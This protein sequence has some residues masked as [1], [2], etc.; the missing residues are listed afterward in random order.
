MADGSTA[1]VDDAFL[2]A[3]ITDP[4]AR[5]VKGFPPVMPKVPLSDEELSALVDYIK[6]LGVAP[7]A[8]E[9]KAQR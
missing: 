5:H 3:F 8:G 4:Q 6:T 2:R 1:L 9:Q 7:P